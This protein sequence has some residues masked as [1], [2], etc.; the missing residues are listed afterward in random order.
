M[1]L[2][3]I[4]PLIGNIQSSSSFDLMPFNTI[5]LKD[6]IYKLDSKP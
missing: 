6:S 1:H 3:Q 4:C 2:P 5:I